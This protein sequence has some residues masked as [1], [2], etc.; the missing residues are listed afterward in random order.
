MKNENIKEENLRLPNGVVL[1]PEAM[2]M[3]H[4][5]QFNEGYLNYDGRKNQD[6]ALYTNIIT[7]VQ[8]RIAETAHEFTKD[9]HENWRNYLLHVANLVDIKRII[10]VFAHP[11][12]E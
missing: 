5:L 1:T 6:I 9:E 10:N 8:D 4:Q 7:E 2:K 3:L 11:G 12:G